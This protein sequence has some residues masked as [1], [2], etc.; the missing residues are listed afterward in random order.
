MSG[1]LRIEIRT[2]GKKRKHGNRCSTVLFTKNMHHLPEIKIIS[3]DFFIF[4][5]IPKLK[6]KKDT[7]NKFDNFHSIF[8]NLK[9][10]DI[11]KK[12]F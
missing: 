10:F 8:L 3:G 6:K 7:F 1:E 4:I 11:P 2:S 9:L 5:M 12:N